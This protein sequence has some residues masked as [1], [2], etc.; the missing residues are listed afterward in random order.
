MDRT[1]LYTFSL[2]WIGFYVSMSLSRDEGSTNRNKIS[3]AALRNDRYFHEK[4]NKFCTAIGLVSSWRINAEAVIQRPYFTKKELHCSCLSFMFY[5]NIE[6]KLGK[7]INVVISKLV[8]HTQH[9][10]RVM[11]KCRQRHSLKSAK[12][13]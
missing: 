3:H 5:I 11:Q 6:R 9:V 10:K 1:N 12:H 4:L 7:S 13:K 2:Y 8:N